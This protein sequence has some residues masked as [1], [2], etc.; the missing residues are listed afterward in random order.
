MVDAVQ[1][2][3]GNEIVSSALSGA[4]LGGLDFAIGGELT[5]AVGGMDSGGESAFSSNSAMR[6]V[7]RHGEV[8]YNAEDPSLK[9]LRPSGGQPLPADMLARFNSAFGKDFSHVRVHTDGMAGMQARALNAHAF[10]MGSHIWF[11]SGAF[12]PGTRKGD[13]LIAHELTHVVQNDQ[14]RMASSSGDGM[15]VSQ[16]NDPLEREAYSNEGR[17][18]SMLPS[19]DAELAAET[20]EPTVDVSNMDLSSDMAAASAAPASVEGS[21]AAESAEVGASESSGAEGPAMRSAAGPGMPQIPG[22]EGRN[23]PL[24]KKAKKRLAELTNK[25]TSQ[26]GAVGDQIKGGV[27]PD[28]KQLINKL[29]ETTGGVSLDSAPQDLLPLGGEETKELQ[30][31]IERIRS[32]GAGDVVEKFANVLPLQGNLDFSSAIDGDITQPM[33]Q[34]RAQAR[35]KLA[36]TPLGKAFAKRES[37]LKQ[38]DGQAADSYVQA[39]SGKRLPAAIAKRLGTALGADF[40]KVTVHTDAS[41][42]KAA[43][44]LNAKA[45]ALGSHVFFGEGQYNPSSQKG[46]E[47]LGHE[48]VHVKQHNEGRLNSQGS[49]DGIDVSSKSDAPEREAYALEA[50]LGDALSGDTSMDSGL[51]SGLDTGVAAG[52]ESGAAVGGDASLAMR[53]ENDTPATTSESSE[54]KEE[55][56]EKPDSVTVNLAGTEIVFDIPSDNESLRQVVPLSME[57][58]PGL[59]AKQAELHFNEDWEFQSGS[60]E[61]TLNA[62]EILKDVAVKLGIDESKNVDCS[63]KDVALNVGGLVSATMDLTVGTSGVSGEA[64][65]THEQFSLGE[66]YTME[67]GEVTVALSEGGELSMDGQ[68]TGNAAGVGTFTLTATADAEGI[69][70]QLGI[71]LDKPVEMGGGVSI[72]G[73]SLGGDYKSTAESTL[74]GTVEMAIRDWATGSL[75]ATYTMPAGEQTGGADGATSMNQDGGETDASGGDTGGGGGGQQQAAPAPSTAPS[76]GSS[77]TSSPSPSQGDQSQAPSAPQGQQSPATGEGGQEE[78]QEQS[79]ESGQAVESGGQ[80]GGGGPLTVAGPGSWAISGTL[81]QTRNFDVAEGVTVSGSELTI[82]VVESQLTQIAAKTDLTTNGLTAHLD[83][84]YDVHNEAF[85]GSARVDVTEPQAI[86]G[87]NLTLV[88][89]DATATVQGNVLQNVVGNFVADVNV[90]GTPKVRVEGEAVTYDAETGFLNGEAT[91]SLLEDVNVGTTNGYTI[92]V[93]TDTSATVQLE[94]SEVSQLEGKILGRIDE[95]E[96]EFMTYEAEGT[97]QVAEEQFDG[98]GKA[99]IDVERH[100]ADVAGQSIYM[101]PGA[102]FGATVAENTLTELNGEVTLSVRSPEEWASIKLEGASDL[103]SEEGVSGTGTVTITADKELATMGKYTLALAAKEGASTTAHVEAGALTKIDGQIPFKVGDG[104]EQALIDGNVSGEYTVDGNS[105]TGSG[106]LALARDVITEMGTASLVVKAGTGGSGDVA[107]NNLETINGTLQ[108]EVQVNGETEVDIGGTATYAVEEEK[109]VE[110]TATA[111][112]RRTLK[113]FGENV[114]ELSNLSGSATFEDGEL[115]EISGSVSI[116]VPMLEGT[117]GTATI[118]WRKEGDKD[119]VSGSGTLHVVLFKGENGRGAEGDVTVSFKEDGTFSVDGDVDYR[120]NETIGGSIG[121]QMDQELDPVLDG[122][123]EINSTLVQASELFRMNF[124]LIPEVDLQFAVGP[125]PVIISFGAAAGMGLGMQALVLNA[126]VGVSNFKPLSEGSEVPNFDT[127]LDMSWGLNFDAMASAWMS[128]GL[129]VSVANVS[130]GIRGEVALDAPL[131]VTPHGSLHGGP[132]GFWGELG[133]GISLSSSVELRAIPFI[134]AELAGFDAYQHDFEGVTADLGEVFGF[135]WGTTYEFGDKQGKREG[136]AE[137]VQGPGTQQAQ[138]ENSTRP[139][140]LQGG[141]TS[142]TPKSAPGGPQMDDGASIAGDQE[143][144]GGGQLAELQE[145]LATIRTLTEGIAGLADLADVLIKVLSGL[146]FGPIG[147]V[148]NLAWYMVKGEITWERVSGAWDRAKAGI[149]LAWDMIQPMLPEWWAHLQR[150]IS[151]G[152]PDLW[153]AF[154]GADD[155]MVEAVNRG[156]HRHGPNEML[157]EMVDTILDGWVGEAHENAIMSILQEAQKRG[158]FVSLVRRFGAENIGAQMDDTAHNQR[159]WRKMCE[160]TGIGRNVWVEGWV[161]DGWEWQY[162]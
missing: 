154:F 94:D 16:P 18:A 34:G 45:F 69:G 73:G 47:L 162:R 110:A 139:S 13:T 61:G 40:G 87:G 8:G 85:S 111:T 76:T 19:I 25:V 102:E 103:T 147:F 31:L 35:K 23:I 109:L 2:W 158:C 54:E 140:T 5:L 17:I 7:M 156:D 119:L 15:D 50:Q 124:D 70:G 66:N 71:V 41:A 48:L 37:T 118:A 75:Q 144:G 135:E 9:S 62:G 12:D 72:T 141:N 129:G 11:S 155:L 151:D 116:A 81:T 38:V 86:A 117:T 58:V 14:G 97:Y 30:D 138:T 46:K 53:A 99:S 159:K 43:D 10:T 150:A 36:K 134:K 101:A 104:G 63:V 136:A 92:W 44:A 152:P 67:G 78:G 106:E 55:G 137:A 96:N 132:D 157:F 128:A 27:A 20:S 60:I 98:S 127:E 108:A 91:A 146:A 148:V 4:D 115:T 114:V 112:L 51:D 113:P 95:G 59:M 107:E 74:S 161:Y 120:L 22:I 6:S 142:K 80:G 32:E 39:S 153:Q 56:G 100:L 64:T 42:V 131:T 130:G 133:V 21:V 143:R 105:F 24:P 82:D 84:T 1:G 122:N 65:F 125:V 126:N 3:F 68:L 77:E 149:E 160:D 90:D 145:N 89:A 33:A 121:M 26:L 57:L 49:G 28:P 79:Q 93:G 83:G 52:V 123:L 29:N 88:S